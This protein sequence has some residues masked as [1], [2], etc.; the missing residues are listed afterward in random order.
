MWHH[1]CCRARHRS[2]TNPIPGTLKR[3]DALS[4]MVPPNPIHGTREK[5]QALPRLV[6]SSFS[7][8]PRG[9]ALPPAGLG[10]SG[11]LW[12]PTLQPHCWA[13]AAS[14]GTIPSAPC[15]RELEGEGLGGFSI[16]PA[17]WR[18]LGLFGAQS[19]TR[20]LVCMQ[21]DKGNGGNV[22]A[23]PTYEVTAHTGMGH[24]GPFCAFWGLSTQPRGE[25]APHGM[26]GCSPAPEHPAHGVARLDLTT[27]LCWVSVS[28]F[29]L[30]QR[31]QPQFLGAVL[32]KSN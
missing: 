27:M 29:A 19:C 20:A 23:G 5:L 12:F 3:R 28:M 32:L 4:G 13:R 11:G 24:R 8:A 26:R 14:Q 15:G 30:S 9:S 18:Q 6:L 1:R 22:T 16:A 10:L 17:R 31:L 2:S 7:G 21:A 25:G